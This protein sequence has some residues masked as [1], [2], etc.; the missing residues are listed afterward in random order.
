MQHL[1]V[2]CAV[3]PIEWPLGVKWLRNPTY[4]TSFVNSCWCRQHNEKYINFYLALFIETGAD[5]FHSMNLP[6]S[7]PLRERIKA[8]VILLLNTLFSPAPSMIVKNG[9][10]H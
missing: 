3:R 2:S 8:T 7:Y 1:E 4:A 5:I 10:S 9:A 6:V